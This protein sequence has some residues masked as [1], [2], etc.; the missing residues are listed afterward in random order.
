[1]FVCF[2]KC[3]CVYMYV[4]VCMYVDLSWCVCVGVVSMSVF[5]FCVHGDVVCTLSYVEIDARR[6]CSPPA[7]DAA[8]P[9]PKGE[10]VHDPCIAA[11]T[12]T[13]GDRGRSRARLTSPLVVCRLANL[14]TTFHSL[15]PLRAKLDPKKALGWTNHKTLQLSPV[16]SKWDA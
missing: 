13:S 5:A 11:P 3:F 2:C 14:L 15:E 9:L 10:T 6:C 16:S 7:P 8:A 1:M 12:S 4:Y